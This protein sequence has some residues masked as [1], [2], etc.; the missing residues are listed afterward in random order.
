MVLCQIQGGRINRQRS[1]QGQ[2]RQ[3]KV[4]KVTLMLLAYDKMQSRLRD[5][6]W[7]EKNRIIA[8]GIKIKGIK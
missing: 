3:M 5:K 2:L 8:F 7:I 1:N 6:G 4:Y